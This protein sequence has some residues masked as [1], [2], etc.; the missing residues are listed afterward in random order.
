MK[1]MTRATMLLVAATALLIGTLGC[2]GAEQ[3]E[4]AQQTAALLCTQ[5]SGECKSLCQDAYNNDQGDNTTHMKRELMDC[6][7]KCDV[8]PNH[9]CPHLE[10]D[11]CVQWC[12]GDKFKIASF[13]ICNYTS[14]SPGMA[15]ADPR[16][17]ADCAAK[18]KKACVDNCF[19]P[20][21]KVFVPGEG[22][23]KP[24]LAP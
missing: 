8:N 22:M 3:L 9:N 18:K 17:V 5:T 11:Q 6:K 19:D 4:V 2:G 13:A 12:E 16:A 21:R 10:I 20:E 15:Q 1:K 14:A 7:K 23:V 24:P